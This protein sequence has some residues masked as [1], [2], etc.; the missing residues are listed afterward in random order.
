MRVERGFGWVVLAVLLACPARSEAGT[1][2]GTVIDRDGKPA[3]GAK[4]WAAKIA[5]SEPQET[6]EATA[7]ASGAFAVE[8]GDGTWAVFALR[9]DE[10]GRVGYDAFPTVEKGKDPE[11]AKIRLGPPTRLKGRLLDAET[12]GPVPGGRFALDD[13][14]RLEVDARG[15]FEVPGLEA[16]HHEAYTVC[17]GYERRRF[18]FDTTGRPDAELELR[19]PRA[20][21]VVGRVVDE[22]G[23][24]IAGAVV[25]HNTSGTIFSG[26]ALWERCSEDGLF[27]YDGKPLGQ[28]G[29]LS[30]LAPGFLA[31]DRDDVLTL[32]PGAPAE[33]DFTLKPEPPKEAPMAKPA[34]LPA[35]LRNVSGTV[36][37]P[38]G[39]PL[40]SAEVRWGPNLTGNDVA[41][42]TTD[43]AGDF[44]LRG[45]PDEKNVLAV[46]APGLAT[47]FLPVEAGG[48]RAVSVGL[49]RGST[50][51]G[52]VVDEDGKPIEDAQVIPQVKDPRPNF[53]GSVY[54]NRPWAKTDRD[55]R[56]TL[57][58]MP[59]GV[60]C[61]VLSVDR[62]DV[63][64][65]PLSATDESANVVTLLGGGAV[66]GRVVDASGK[67][68]RHFRVLLGIPKDAKPGEPVGGFFAG[69]QRTGLSFTRDDG[70]FTV[71]GLT[72]GN[73][74]LITVV[75]DD[76][77]TAKVDRVVASTIA[78]LKP[79]EALTIKLGPAHHLRVRVFGPGGKR[80][81]GAR[82]TV[83][84]TEG[85]VGFQWGPFE[86]GWA[87]SLTARA[88]GDGWADFPSVGFDA[89]TVIVRA[90]GY[91]RRKV[92]WS[93]NEDEL[94]VDL[95]PEARL[96]GKVLDGDGKPLAGVRLR[97]SWGAG[98][99]LDVPVDPRDG[100]YEAD[101]LA[102]GD[103]LWDVGPTGVP[104][105]APSL[106]SGRLALEAGKA[107]T[108]DVRVKKP[109]E[110]LG[111]VRPD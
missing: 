88:G 78:L 34:P 110:P 7:D 87:D 61:D 9:G 20:G 101:A 22:R 42:A 16:T 84:Q 75:A 106:A 60:S 72:A 74:L 43:P 111:P 94:D 63:R 76:L 38:D 12:G 92:D 39:K 103:Y 13:G 40:A 97:L 19:L 45:V 79:A 48:D 41:K 98:E 50:I 33:V 56:F 89:G 28:T 70:E 6:R 62:S 82:A 37:G 4:V 31:Q 108:F 68:V 73:L 23:K 99:S 25:G 57:E 96:T 81:E 35:G 102:P 95:E 11:P 44:L 77:G 46:T 85:R 58:G 93:R 59:A 30:A 71:T 104:A 100:R 105:P 83:I 53:A 5:L 14:R 91:S 109:A 64:R 3:S 67:P 1:I 86:G 65:R 55:G 66:R 8:A 17:P 90:K 47:G 21:K 24:P 2:R 51:R 32:D 36:T 52:R 27:S 15:R 69:Y 26:S 80:I 29:R 54:L 18:L 107:Q 49:D 10:G